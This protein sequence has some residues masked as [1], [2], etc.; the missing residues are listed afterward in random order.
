MTAIERERKKDWLTSDNVAEMV[1]E[2]DQDFLSTTPGNTANVMIDR[3]GAVP[4]VEMSLDAAD[5]SVCATLRGASNQLN[6]A[7]G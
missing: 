6:F 4:S 1:D 2:P 5:T 3:T 7:G